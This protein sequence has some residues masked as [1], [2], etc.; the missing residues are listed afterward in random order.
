MRP[1]IAF[2]VN[3]LSQFLHAP[4][5]EHWS[6]CKRVLGYSKGTTEI[7]LQFRPSKRLNL[8]CFSDA[9][10]ASSPDDR[11][12]TSGYY[13]FLGGNLINWSSRKQKEVARSS[14]ESEY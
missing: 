11:K 6:T 5:M 8:E 2:A 9:D 3:K 10:W 13:V 14:T 12:S 1:D 4:T 7:G